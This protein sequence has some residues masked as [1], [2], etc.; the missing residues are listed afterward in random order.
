MSNRIE[1]EEGWSKIQ[2]NIDRLVRFLWVNPPGGT[3]K[4]NNQE[5]LSTFTQVYTMCTQKPPYNYSEQLYERSKQ[6]VEQ[7]FND[8]VIPNLDIDPESGITS[9]SIKTQWSLFCIFVKWMNSFF[10]Y[11]DR[12]HTKRQGLPSFKDMGHA[13][14]RDYLRKSLSEDVISE[15][16]YRQS[17]NLK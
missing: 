11:L 16:T 9:E 2:P 15:L 8:N 14:F 4:I 13:V 12:F 1:L 7:V 3:P 6:T 5:Y 10:S 17:N